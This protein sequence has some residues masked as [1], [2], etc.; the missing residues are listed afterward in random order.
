MLQTL[1]SA[2]LHVLGML[3]GSALEQNSQHTRQV[4]ILRG[5]RYITK[6]TTLVWDNAIPRNVLQV[7]LTATATVTATATA[8][9][10][11]FRWIQEDVSES[12]RI[13]PKDLR[14]SHNSCACKCTNEI[15]LR[16]R[17]P[18][19]LWPLWKIL[20]VSCNRL[21]VLCFNVLFMVFLSSTLSM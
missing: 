7:D 11:Y 9:A 2:A 15:V 4:N 8:T 5:L 10:T 17:I 13:C 6:H 18:C 3:R 12:M 19:D 20:A 21:R 1:Y 16:S 14:L